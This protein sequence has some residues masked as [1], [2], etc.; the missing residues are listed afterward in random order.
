[1]D[2][3]HLLFSPPHISHTVTDLEYTILN[4]LKASKARELDN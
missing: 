3:S 1:M 4:N 2:A